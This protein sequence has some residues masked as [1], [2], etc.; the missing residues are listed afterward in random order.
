MDATERGRRP[1]IVPDS[2]RLGSGL[3]SALIVGGLLELPYKD[4]AN[5][6]QMIQQQ[7]DEQMK[8]AAAK[9]EPPKELR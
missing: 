9:P 4:A 2:L 8:A 6:L 5:V 7:I 1:D 3:R